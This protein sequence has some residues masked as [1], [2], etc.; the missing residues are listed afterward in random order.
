MIQVLQNNDGSQTHLGMIHAEV[1]PHLCHPA[2]G[3]VS[4][5]LSP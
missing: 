4:C 2:E 3:K 5:L 1:R